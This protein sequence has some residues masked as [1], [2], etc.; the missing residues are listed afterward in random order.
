MRHV[1]LIGLAV[2]LI[3]PTLVAG[4][5]LIKSHTPLSY[6]GKIGVCMHLS[7]FDS[8]T[9]AAMLDLG[10]RWVRIDWIIG[11]MDLFIER[12]FS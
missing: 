6:A 5:L 9:E 1:W 10:V 8:Q 7:D 11:E 2:I 3:I 12:E 4:A